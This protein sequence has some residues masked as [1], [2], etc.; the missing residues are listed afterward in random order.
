MYGKSSFNYLITLVF[1]VT[2]LFWDLADKK[3][4]DSGKDL[5]VTF[6]IEWNFNW[7]ESLFPF[8]WSLFQTWWFFAGRVKAILKV[9]LHTILGTLMPWIYII[10][11]WYNTEI[12]SEN[13][14]FGC[15]FQSICKLGTCFSFYKH[16]A[17]KHI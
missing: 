2:T 1:F 17:Y 11:I 14:T 6:A 5:F 16:Y 9:L 12:S 15:P 8:N 13:E 7:R 10:N 3:G 4:I